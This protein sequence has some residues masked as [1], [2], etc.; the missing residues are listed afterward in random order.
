VDDH[1]QLRGLQHLNPTGLSPVMGMHQKTRKAI[2]PMAPSITI[3]RLTDS[4]KIEKWFT[5]NFSRYATANIRCK[6]RHSLYIITFKPIDSE[7]AALYIFNH[8]PI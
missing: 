6:L 4:A 1:S 2:D 5:R 8:R 3:D 7:P